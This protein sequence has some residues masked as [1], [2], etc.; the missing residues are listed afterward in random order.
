MDNKTSELAKQASQFLF[1][2]KRIFSLVE[3][4]KCMITDENMDVCRGVSSQQ[5]AGGTKFLP[6]FSQ[7]P[8]IFNEIIRRIQQRVRK[9]CIL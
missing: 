2:A 7:K 3:F 9:A 4:D 1:C 6:D 8:N 5:A